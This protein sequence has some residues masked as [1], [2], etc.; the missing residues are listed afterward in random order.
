[1][2]LPEEER[3]RVGRH[4]CLGGFFGDRAGS[5]EDCYNYNQRNGVGSGKLGGLGAFEDM[6]ESVCGCNGNGGLQGFFGV[7]LELDFHCRRQWGTNESII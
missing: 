7:K 5:I 2:R 6:A 1:M 3:D 4:T